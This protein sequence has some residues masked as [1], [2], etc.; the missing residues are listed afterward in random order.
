MSAALA[1]LI[2]EASERFMGW[3]LVVAE[4]RGQVLDQPLAPKSRVALV[5]LAFAGRKFRGAKFDLRSHALFTNVKVSD[6]GQ[7]PKKLNLSVSQS[8]GS[9][10]LD[11]LV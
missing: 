4:P 10:L 9:H 6:W 3:L 5:L 11:R 2:F 1:A 8:V 7:S